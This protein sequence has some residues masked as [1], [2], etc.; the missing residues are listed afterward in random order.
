MRLV[1]NADEVCGQVA[2]TPDVALIN[3][4]EPVDTLC[5]SILPRMISI[6]IRKYT[7]QPNDRE[8]AV[9][10]LLTNCVRLAI[11]HLGR[12]TAASIALAALQ[13]PS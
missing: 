8:P 10:M 3:P 1:H 4:R 2:A 13:E 12:E 11:Y 6:A 5:M 7:T 9:R